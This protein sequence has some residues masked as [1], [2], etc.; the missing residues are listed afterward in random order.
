MKLLVY[1]IKNYERHY[2]ENANKFH[3]QVDYTN[4][5]LSIETAGKARGYDS[6]CIFTH[7]VA[8]EPVLKILQLGGTKYIAVRAAGYDNVD[9][10]AA[11]CLGIHVANVPAYSPYAVAEHA[12]ALI[13]ALN[14]KLMIADRN[15]HDYDFTIS[16]LIGTDLH[17]KTAGIIGTGTIGSVMANIL[18]G[19]GCHLLGF[20]IRE[21]RELVERYN[22][23]YTDL[24][25]LCFAAD[26]ISVH[27]SLNEQTRHLINRDVIGY[28]R[29]NVI[30]VNTA[31]GAVVDTDALADALESGIVG[32]AGLDVYEH[33][34]GIFFED[35]GS[36]K[37]K[38]P[39]LRKLLNLPNVMITPHQAFATTEALQNIASTTF[40]NLHTWACNRLPQSELGRVSDKQGK[41]ARVHIL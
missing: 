1:S 13:L 6:V 39:L 20:D 23:Q 3:V 2:L 37:L 15:V 18:H 41:D 29:P 34:K 14:R 40:N 16:K 36:Q 7:D 5:P 10:A 30:F 21:N 17:G 12:M 32:A 9:I 11:N 8:D 33:E 19:F 24:K 27:L 28:M 4:K 38:D 25:G 35:H 31:R 22:M 26:V